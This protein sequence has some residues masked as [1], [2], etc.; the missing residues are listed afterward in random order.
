MVEPISS[1]ATGTSLL[2]SVGGLFG[3]KKAKTANAQKPYFRPVNE[4]IGEMERIRD[5]LQANTEFVDRP[6]RRLTQEELADSVFTPQAIQDLQAYFDNKKV[7]ESLDDN[8]YKNKNL[9][10][11]G[12]DYVTSYGNSGKV[13]PTYWANLN[14]NANFD[15][16]AIAKALLDI[17]NN[18]NSFKQNE[19]YLRQ[20]GLGY[21]PA[22]MPRGVSVPASG[23]PR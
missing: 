19:S 18:P 14:K 23:I 9:Y 15:F 1:I 17:Q 22:A 20:I 7:E 21:M 13:N 6:M 10:Q 8:P 3:K 4:T 12:R 5:Y 11:I 16:E 2:S